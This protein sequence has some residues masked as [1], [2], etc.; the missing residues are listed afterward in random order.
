MLFALLFP[1][2]PG[3]DSLEIR[4]D[5][6]A[7]LTETPTSAPAAKKPAT[8]TSRPAKPAPASGDACGIKVTQDRDE[9]AQTYYVKGER[10]FNDDSIGDAKQA[11]RAAVCLNPKHKQAAD[12]LQ[13]LEKT[14]PKR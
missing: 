1:L 2:L 13:L 9:L 8:T 4:P 7:P 11:L 6:E 3:C 5:G 12:L 14:Y 10:L